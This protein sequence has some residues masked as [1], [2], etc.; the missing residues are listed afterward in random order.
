M[1]IWRQKI[2]CKAQ[3]ES[4][5]STCPHDADGH[6]QPWSYVAFPCQPDP[7]SPV[8]GRLRFSIVIAV[9]ACALGI[10]ASAADLVGKVV[11]IAD[12]DTLTLLVAKSQHKVRLVGIDTPEKGQPFGD[13]AKKALSALVFGKTVRVVENDKDRYG[14]TLGHVPRAVRP[15][16]P[17][18]NLTKFTVPSARGCPHRRSPLAARGTCGR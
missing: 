6:G 13:A 15:S 9:A 5:G 12:G 2:D 1:K 7:I 16:A 17:M 18:V 4:C 3:N 14:R 8:L 11:A 10:S